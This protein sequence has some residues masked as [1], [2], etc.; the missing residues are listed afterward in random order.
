MVWISCTSSRS[1]MPTNSN[2]S[3]R[4]FG[5][6]VLPCALN[7]VLWV[8]MLSF[9]SSAFVK[10]GEIVSADA[11]GVPWLAV[12]ADA[13]GLPLLLVCGVPLLPFLFDV[14]VIYPPP[15]FAK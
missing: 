3:W 13:L 4:K 8:G 10:P 12:S 9:N 11:L 15:H 7:V 14:A 6:V 2:H 5:R 1:R